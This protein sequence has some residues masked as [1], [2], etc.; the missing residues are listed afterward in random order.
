MQIAAAYGVQIF[1]SSSTAFESFMV[2]CENHASRSAVQRIRRSA[3]QTAAKPLDGIRNQDPA[4]LP[5]VIASEAATVRRSGRWHQV[6]Q[7]VP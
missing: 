2:L 5:R 6:E 4:I 1:G 3:R 7:S